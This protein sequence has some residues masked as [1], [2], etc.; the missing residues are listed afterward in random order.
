VVDGRAYR[1]GEGG[2]GRAGRTVRGGLLRVRHH[3]VALD[4]GPGAIGTG[5]LSLREIDAFDVCVREGRVREVG[6]D[7]VRTIQG[8]H[9]DRI[10]EL[11]GY[12]SGSVVV[13]R[14]DL[15]LV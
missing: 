12:A 10:A 4:A 2:G 1:G 14:D 15:I 6:A 3:V 5:D 7:D 11:L 9:S 8:H 13:H